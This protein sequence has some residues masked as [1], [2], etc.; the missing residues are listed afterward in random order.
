MTHVLDVPVAGVREQVFMRAFGLC[1]R[2]GGPMR[3]DDFEAHHRR[4]RNV[5]GWCPCNIVALHPR[6][7]TQ[8]PLAVHDNVAQA[9]R[10]GLI[11]P[12]YG[13]EPF[14]VPLVVHSESA[15]RVHVVERVLLSC[16]GLTTRLAD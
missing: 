12:T 10:M 6:C 9:R 5:L 16:D 1:A 13:P 8:G 14:D 11:V 7:H 4:R 15:H 3:F 2:C